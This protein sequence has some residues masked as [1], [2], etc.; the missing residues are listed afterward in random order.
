METNVGSAVKE[1]YIYAFGDGDLVSDPCHQY[2]HI[3][4]QLFLPRN[5]VLLHSLISVSVSRWS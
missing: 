4:H 2:H 3:R 1:I 5:D